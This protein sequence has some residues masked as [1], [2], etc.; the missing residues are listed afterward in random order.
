MDFR[1]GGSR[2]AIHKDN[3][4]PEAHEITSAPTLVESGSCQNAQEVNVNKHRHLRF[5]RETTVDVE[6]VVMTQ[7]NIVRICRDIRKGVRCANMQ[8][9][10]QDVN[11]R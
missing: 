1:S 10:N 4:Y 2:R 3:Q 8:Y 11:N 6:R 7:E 9:A 5:M